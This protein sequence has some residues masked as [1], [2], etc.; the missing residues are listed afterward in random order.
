[1]V[2]KFFSNKAVR[3]QFPTV[4]IMKMLRREGCCDTEGD[5]S[6][7]FGHQ[8]FSQ[9]KC[10]LYYQSGIHPGLREMDRVVKAQKY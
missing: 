7:K 8:Q 9:P 3:M 2:S 4:A 1:M 10:L 6:C 5:C